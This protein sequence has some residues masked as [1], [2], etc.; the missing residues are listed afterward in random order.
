[1]A[2]LDIDPSNRPWPDDTTRVFRPGEPSLDLA[3]IPQT[4]AQWDRYADG[5]KE[6][7][8]RVYQ[9]WHHISNDALVFPVVFLY[10]HYVE[11]RVKELLQSVE[12]LLDLPRGWKSSHD[13][14]DL[15]RHLRPLLQRAHPDEPIRDFDNAERLVVELARNDPL[16]MEF[17]FPEDRAG[18][19]HLADMQRLDV[20]NF[21]AAMQKLAAF[22]NGASVAVSVYRD[23]KRESTNET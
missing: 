5:Y 22:L 10:R 17:R 6:A 19:R 2:D 9:S 4:S 12:R 13:I 23:T 11:L 8:D 14:V 7:A 18:K 20:V 15:W 16:A 1:M 21:Y 3:W